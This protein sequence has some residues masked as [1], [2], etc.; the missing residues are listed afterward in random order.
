MQKRH[1]IIGKFKM[2]QLNSTQNK[3]AASLKNNV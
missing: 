3:N 2:L 1:V